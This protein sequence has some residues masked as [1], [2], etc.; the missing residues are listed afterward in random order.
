MPLFPIIFLCD[1]GRDYRGGVSFVD[2]KNWKKNS[3]VLDI[4]KPFCTYKKTSGRGGLVMAMWLTGGEKHKAKGKE[5]ADIVH[6]L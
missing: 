5:R 6:V 4:W 2:S 3:R 1:K